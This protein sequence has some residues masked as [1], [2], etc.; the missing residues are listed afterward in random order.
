MT[1]RR[2]SYVAIVDDDESVCRS[3]G[4]LIRTAGYQPI[5]YASAEDFLADTKRPN[6]DCIVLDF[7]LTGISGLELSQRLAA[8]N[9]VTPVIFITAQDG[10]THRDEAISTGCAGYFR[11]TDPGT[12]ILDAIQNIVHCDNES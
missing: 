1:S 4:R 6:F 11:K 7:Q 9:D 5:T 10:D 3:F 8:V 2:N 12:L